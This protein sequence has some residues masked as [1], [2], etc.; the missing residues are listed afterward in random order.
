MIPSKETIKEH[1]EYIHDEL[2]LNDEWDIEV[3]VRPYV[4]ADLFYEIHG[5]EKKIEVIVYSAR[6]PQT[7]SNHVDEAISE[8]RKGFDNLTK[9][10]EISSPFAK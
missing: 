5:D 9:E 3:D 6:Y 1:E 7:W 2:E 4:M 8:M 10:G